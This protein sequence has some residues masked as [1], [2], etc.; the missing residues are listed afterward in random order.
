MDK[1]DPISTLPTELVPD[2]DAIHL[3]EL[4]YKQEL[5]R[6]F[7]QWSLVA[8]GVTFTATWTALGG[9][10]GTGIYSGGAPGIIYGFVSR[11]SP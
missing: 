7:S 8:F 3:A 2:S 5:K 6:H 11:S 1:S 4:G 10:L 9:G